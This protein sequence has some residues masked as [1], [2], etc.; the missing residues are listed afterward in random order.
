VIVD[1][2]DKQQIVTP[3][4]AHLAGY[5]PETGKKLWSIEHKNQWGTI[6]TTPVVDDSGRVFISAAEVGAMLVDPSADETHLR[7]WATDGTA[8][9]HSN[10]VRAGDVVYASV[11]ESASFITAISLTDGK[12]AW[13]KRGFATADLDAAAADRQHALLPR[14]DPDRGAGPFCGPVAASIQVPRSAQKVQRPASL[15]T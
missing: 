2:G 12:Q 8:I 4:E 13:K 7:V 10:A 5:D 6:L 15:R 3:V 1:V 14:R 9:N 11:G